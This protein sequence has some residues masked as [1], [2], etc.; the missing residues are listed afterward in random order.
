MALCSSGMNLHT[1]G[2]EVDIFVPSKHPLVKLANNI[3]WELISKDV[4]RDLIFTT[5]FGYWHVGRKLKVRI[6]LAAYFLRVMFNM[7]YRQA[8]RE[9]RDNAAYQVFCGR[10]IVDRWHV[11]D[12]TKM[13]DFQ[14]RL[15]PETHQKLANM[16]TEIAEVYGFADPQQ[17]DLDSTVQEANARGASEIYLL[18][19]LASYA[20]RVKK[21]IESYLPRRLMHLALLPLE[22][23]KIQVYAKYHMIYGKGSSGMKAW[24]LGKMKDLI[25]PIILSMKG[26]S[27]LQKKKEINLPHRLSRYL[28]LIDKNF[29]KLLENVN[30]YIQRG[31]GQKQRV[32][33]LHLEEMAAFVKGRKNGLKVKYG[34]QWQV[35]RI[36]G[37]F[38]IVG[39]SNRA[40]SPDQ[41]AVSSMIE[42]HEELFGSNTLKSFVTDR[43]YYSKK[44]FALLSTIKDDNPDFIFHLPAQGVKD[45][46]LSEQDHLLHNRR[47][48]VEALIGQTKAG[49]QLGRSRA[50]TDLGFKNSGYNSVLGFNLRQFTRYLMAEE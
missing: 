27:V 17:M 45:Y 38:L 32:L 16:I 34:R 10:G 12:H 24:T 29:L 50:K 31:V 43:G 36:G 46:Q 47:S 7:T 4:V 39:E 49:G 28:S 35:G 37:N 2:G 40:R 15:S 25:F 22:I 8:E 20:F 9:L 23:R 6:H 14:K 48:G 21:D 19:R 33:S 1:S 41:E 5:R 42:L 11:P 44:N 30:Y 26:L 18:E 13:F 3:P